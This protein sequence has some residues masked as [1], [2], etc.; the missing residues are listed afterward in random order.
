M[1]KL[2][3]K[4]FLAEGE[5][6]EVYAKMIA[7]APAWSPSEAESNYK[8]GSITFSAA[9]GLGSVPYNQSVYYHGFVAMMKPSV[10]LKLALPHGGERDEDSAKIEA[11]VKKGYALGIPFLDLNINDLEEGT[12]PAKIVGHEG[13]ARTLFVLRELGDVPFPVQFLLKGGARAR[14]LTPEVMASMK[15]EI[16]AQ[17]KQSLVKNPFA[18]AFV[19][20]ES[21]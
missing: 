2:T 15:N 20:G 12:G 19:R 9:D 10:F 3:F 11:L 1:S 18:E 6:R 21:A 16:L 5:E 13:R 8:I 4:Q 7:D 14:D 17:D